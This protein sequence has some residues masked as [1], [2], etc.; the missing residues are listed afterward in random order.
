MGFIINLFS[1]NI[2]SHI[3]GHDHWMMPISIEIISSFLLV[4][5]LINSLI[6]TYFPTFFNGNIRIADLSLNITGMTCNN[7]INS[8]KRSILQVENVESVDIM[9]STGNAEIGGS[10]MNVEKIIDA[11]KSAGFTA[12][13]INRK[14]EG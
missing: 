4:L 14:T 11:I 9:L 12:K 13:I 6:R 10:N 2:E 5:I 7:C 8:A 3:H 1:I